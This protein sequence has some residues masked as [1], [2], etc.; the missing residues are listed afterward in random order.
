[1][2]LQGMREFVQHGL[3]KFFLFF[4]LLGFSE[5]TSQELAS[6]LFDRESAKQHFDHDIWTEYFDTFSRYHA[7]DHFWSPDEREAYKIGRYIKKN[8]KK[9]FLKYISEKK[10]QNQ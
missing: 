8:Y 5:I 4:I 6:K 9:D 10:L 3:Y 2:I 7:Y 1:M